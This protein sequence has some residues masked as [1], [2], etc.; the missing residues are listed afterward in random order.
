MLEISNVTKIYSSNHKRKTKVALDNISFSLDNG[1]YGL[2]GPNGSGKSTLIKIIT[3]NLIPTRGFIKWNERTASGKNFRRDLGYMPQQQRLYDNF[4][5]SEFLAYFAAL[6]EIPAKNMNAEIVRVAKMFHIDDRLNDR[7]FHYSGGM[8]QRLL[9]ATSLLGNPKLLI[10][11]EPTAGLD[12]KERVQMR[13][14]LSNLSNNCTI[15]VATHVVS[16]IESVAKE[17][18]LLKNGKIFDKSSPTSLIDKYAPMGNL[19]DVYI[20]TFE[21]D[22]K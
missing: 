15:L 2:L 17:V 7:L 1:L 3:G 22:S 21:R 6:K 16:D 18:I 4:T 20:A 8:K 19:E 10:M 5:G 12:P 9:A 14:I 13:T 11:D